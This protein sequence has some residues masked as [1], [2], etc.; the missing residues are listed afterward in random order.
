[1]YKVTI[2]NEV[3]FA[4]KGEVLSEVL[5]KNGKTVQHICGGKGICGKCGVTVDGKKE[6]SCKYKIEKDIFVELPNKNIVLSE[7]GVEETGTFTENMC[8]VLD[9]G[10]TTLALAL[11]SFDTKK[12]IGVK[13]YINPQVSFGTDVMTRIGYCVNNDVGTLQK[14]LI[15]SIEKAAN[16]FSVGRLPKMYVT[17]NTVMLHIFFGVNPESL[18]VY[19][20]T[21]VF[22]NGRKEKSFL[23][24]A[25]E[26]ES[27]PSI[28]AFFGADLTAGM[29][30]AGF[31]SKDKFNLLVDLGTN[32]EIVLYSQ[33]KALCTSAA[34]GP[35]FEGAGISC[36]MSAVSGAVYAFD[37][38][39]VKTVGKTE[40]EGICG[41]GLIDIIAQLLKNGTVD[42]T[43]Y[44]KNKK[45]FLSRKVYLSDRDVRRY[46]L[47]KS[48]VF[49]AIKI[50]MKRQGANFDSIEKMYI[51]GGFSSKIN[52][53]NAVFTGLLPKELRDKCVTVNN[54][55]LLGTVKFACEK[56]NLEKLVEIAEYTDLASDSDFAEEFIKNT[57]FEI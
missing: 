1:M 12:V 11:V 35:C 38:N 20:H 16:D 19:P 26:I 21:P 3:L 52:I 29:N 2:D 23:K 25:V 41:T 57:E 15:T 18:G 6:L 43:G 34:A 5:I 30:F 48:A 10:T 31:P 44:M 22:L 33:E 45:Y 9:I 40:P 8:Y 50:L 14:A 36:G 24:C 32:A 42:K 47:A 56:N 55:S 17:G 53:D 54:T 37:G 51:S 49:T 39:N 7:S 4:E 13:T 28:S 46:Q 27:L